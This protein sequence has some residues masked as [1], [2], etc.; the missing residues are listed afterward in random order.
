MELE[1]LEF[2][3]LLLTGAQGGLRSLQGRVPMG[4]SL[5]SRRLEA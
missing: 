3:L 1:R 2:C 4:V 5:E